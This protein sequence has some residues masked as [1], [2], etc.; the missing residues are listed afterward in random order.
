MW[1]V[2]GMNI[3]NIF[4]LVNLY[5][6]LIISSCYGLIHL[7]LGLIGRDGALGTLCHGCGF[8]CQQRLLKT[9]PPDPGYLRSEDGVV[10]L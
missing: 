5:V 3:D 2:G 9:F 1:G 7:S 6:W 4:T 10:R 8:A